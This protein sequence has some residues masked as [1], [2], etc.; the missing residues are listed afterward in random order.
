MDYSFFDLQLTFQ[1]QH[2]ALTINNEKKIQ[3]LQETENILP[4]LKGKDVGDSCKW[5]ALVADPIYQYQQIKN[6]LTF[7]EPLTINKV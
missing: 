1:N 3:T 2:N 7:S 4:V 6:Q 5:L